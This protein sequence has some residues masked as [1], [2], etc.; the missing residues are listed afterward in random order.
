MPLVEE[1][2]YL[3]EKA[4]R[5]TKLAKD[6]TSLLFLDYGIIIKFN[7]VDMS[8]S[9]EVRNYHDL[10][11]EIGRLQRDLTRIEFLLSPPKGR[12]REGIYDQALSEKLDE[13]K[14]SNRQLAELHFSL[15][16]PERADVAIRMMDQ[17]LRRATRR[18]KSRELPPK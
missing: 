11:R 8:N 4:M 5:F 9:M 10:N 15:Y 13:P 16:F 1:I 12:P 17:G 18:A 14:L 6:G 2:V 7:Q 3:S